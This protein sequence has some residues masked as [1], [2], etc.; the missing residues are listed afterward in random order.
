MPHPT[1]QHLL[2]VLPLRHL[3]NPASDHLNRCSRH[4]S[5]LTISPPLPLTWMIAE[6]SIWI[7]R[8][9][10]WSSVFYFPYSSQ[11]ASFKISQIVS[12]F[13]SYASYW[14]L[15]EILSLYCGLWPY[16]DLLPLQGSPS[17]WFSTL[18][19]LLPQGLCTYYLPC[20]YH[21]STGYPHGSPVSDFSDLCLD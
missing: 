10:L 19:V 2:L 12:V 11:S 1:H 20:L 21:S 7:S 5:P 15:S 17:P 6:A 14:F 8:I 9:Y 16:L 4:P 13:C 18:I 3:Q